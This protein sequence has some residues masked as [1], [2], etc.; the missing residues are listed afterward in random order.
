MQYKTLALAA[1]LA[2]GAFAAPWNYNTDDSVKVE[3]FQE[4][5][6]HPA[7]TTFSER[8]LPNSKYPYGGNGPFSKINVDLG[9]DVTNK[10]LR[11]QVYGSDGKTPLVGRRGENIDIT[12][13]DADKGAWNFTMPEY[14]SKVICDPA[15]TAVSKQEA[16]IHV[17]LVENGESAIGEDIDDPALKAQESRNLGGGTKFQTINIDLGSIVKLENDALRCAAVDMHNNRF[18]ATRGANLDD[19]FSDADKNEWTFVKSEHDK[20]PAPAEV[21]KIICDPTF[22]ANNRNAA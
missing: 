14:V 17:T 11:C 2:S 19:T 12:F 18:F 6:M 4:G 16:K 15:F 20:T 3:L 21:A 9:K 13:S 10:N 8:Q 22:K 1:S 5:A 7:T